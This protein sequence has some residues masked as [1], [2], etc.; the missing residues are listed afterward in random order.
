M[1][2]RPH[3]LRL[4]TGSLNITIN[5]NKIKEVKSIKFLGVIIDEHLNWKDHVNNI[6][7]KISKAIGVLNRLKSFLPLRILVNLYNTMILPHLSY[8]TVVWGKCAIYLL[9]RIHILQKRAIRVVTNS[10]F[11]TSTDIL[12]KK[13]N[14]L[15]ISDLYTLQAACFMYNYSKGLLPQLFNYYFVLNNCINTYETRNSCNMY[16]PFF[17]YKLSRSSIRFIGPK[18]WNTIDTELKQSPL[19]SSFKRKYKMQLIN[20]YHQNVPT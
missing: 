15:K 1:V 17:H 11:L 7:C 9:N 4:D 19:F 10:H 18:I 8:C 2:F 3:N 13:L 12:F 5:N 16:V 20:K 6:S 14:I